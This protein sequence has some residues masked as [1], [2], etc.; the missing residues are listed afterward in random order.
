MSFLDNYFEVFILI[1]KINK[2]SS[3]PS[4]DEEAKASAPEK[5]TSLLVISFMYE[6]LR[7][8]II[9]IQFCNYLP[10]EASRLRLR[11][12][13]PDTALEAAFAL[14]TAIPFPIANGN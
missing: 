8:K 7:K 6:N 12:Q 4:A 9:H 10:A 2:G 1:L 3:L 13:L 11:R 5:K 14:E